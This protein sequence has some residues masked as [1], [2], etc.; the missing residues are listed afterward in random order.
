MSLRD[1]T[2]KMSKSD[3]S[4]QTRI[5]LVDS[6]ETILSKIKRATTDSIRGISYDRQE[7]PAVANLVEI[8][9]AMKKVSTADVVQ[10]H[11]ESTNAVFKE[12]LADVLI[13]S[14]RPIQEKMSRLQK[15][16]AFVQAVLDKGASRASEIAKPNLEQIQRLVGLR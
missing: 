16:D 7:R 3:L 14:L 13:T 2:N 15:E 1:H 6:P 8:Y 4:D 11:A 5:N 10:E 9:A 12:A